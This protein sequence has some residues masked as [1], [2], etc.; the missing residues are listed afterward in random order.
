MLALSG[1]SL[2]WQECDL[3]IAVSLRVAGCQNKKQTTIT[4]IN[5]FYL[6]IAFWQIYILEVFCFLS[7]SNHYI[8]CAHFIEITQVKY[9]LRFGLQVD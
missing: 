7:M 9:H 1:F 6:I 4:Y 3:S 8:A 2:T 5:L